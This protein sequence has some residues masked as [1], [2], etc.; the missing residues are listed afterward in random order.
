[1]R[2]VLIYKILLCVVLALGISSAV[3]AQHYGYASMYNTSRSGVKGEMGISL[4]G[5]Y[6][7]SS[8]SIDA[9]TLQPRIGAR[10]ALS[11]AMCWH[12]SY[13]LQ[14]ELAYL[15]NKIEA[16]RSPVQY[17]V[18]SGVVEIPVMFS[19]RVL[20]PLRFNVGANFSVVGTG[21]YDLTEERVEFGR[22][23]P[24][25]G[26][27][28]GVGVSLTQHL[29]LE[30]RYTSSFTDTINY[31]EGLEFSTRSHWLTFGIGYMF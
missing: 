11:M 22:L 14:L 7:F 9:V 23:R 29:L 20:W 24:T 12:E 30:A 27:V 16:Q 10:G 8:P 3:Q 6:L 2:K 5:V 31:F 21:R 19:Y 25:L 26:L 4:S 18:K 1:M 17:D 13:A 28:A 15:Y